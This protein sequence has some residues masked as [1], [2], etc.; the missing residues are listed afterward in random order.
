MSCRWH[1]VEPLWVNMAFTLLLTSGPFVGHF[2]SFVSDFP[3]VDRLQPLYMRSGG[4]RVFAMM[5]SGSLSHSL[6]SCENVTLQFKLSSKLPQQSTAE[7]ETVSHHVPEPPTR[8]QH[9][10]LILLLLGTAPVAFFPQ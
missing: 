9:S 7:G 8:S 10:S 5:P 1:C 2:H 6:T 3:A 4:S